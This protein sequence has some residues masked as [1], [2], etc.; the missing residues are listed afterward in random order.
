[1]KAVLNKK[2]AVNLPPLLLMRLSLGERVPSR[3]AVATS[4]RLR[5]C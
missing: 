3:V 5:T 4:G 1:M 2:I